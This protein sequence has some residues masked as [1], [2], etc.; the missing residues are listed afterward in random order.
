[1]PVIIGGATIEPES[2]D[3]GGVG[4][5]RD[6]TGDGDLRRLLLTVV[7]G[8][9]LVDLSSNRDDS[10]SERLPCS[11]GCDDLRTAMYDSDA[12]DDAVEE[13]DDDGEADRPNLS[14]G[15]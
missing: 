13:M 7:G 6:G 14:V 11:L 3:D 5:L 4:E 10:W 1:M 15:G 8:V 12:D 2:G 9:L